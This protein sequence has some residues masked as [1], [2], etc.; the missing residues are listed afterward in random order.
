MQMSFV[1]RQVFD[2]QGGQIV[3]R[4]RVIGGIDIDG[5]KGCPGQDEW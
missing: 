4:H 3:R 2:G 5:A 1:S